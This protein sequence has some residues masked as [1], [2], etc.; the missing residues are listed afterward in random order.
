MK[1]KYLLVLCIATV[2][3]CAALLFRG[4]EIGTVCGPEM[5]QIV[6]NGVIYEQNNDTGL[7]HRD[8]GRYLGRAVN[9]NTTFRVYA[10]KGDTESRY[11]YRLWSW[12][13]AFYERKK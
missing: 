1:K 8:K 2:L 11:L 4:R 6:I 9:D 13:G 10:V 3:L 12:E 5:E 7:S